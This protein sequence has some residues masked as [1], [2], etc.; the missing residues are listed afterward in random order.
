MV[1][2]RLKSKNCVYGVTWQ[3][4]VCVYGVTW[5]VT[6]C[7]SAYL[8]TSLQNIPERPSSTGKSVKFGVK[9]ITLVL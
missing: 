9:N 6:I 3:V 1:K 5:Q 2:G 8:T 7:L 4:T